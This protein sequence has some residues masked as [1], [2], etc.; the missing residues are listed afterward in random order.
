MTLPTPTST[1]IEVIPFRR[2][3][4]AEA[5]FY[6]RVQSSPLSAAPLVRRFVRACRHARV[7]NRLLKPD[8]GVS[9]R[10][11]VGRGALQIASLIEQ[12]GF[13]GTLMLLEARAGRRPA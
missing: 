4:R 6:L 5:G 8:E 10:C 1:A 12:V 9:I 3:G 7:H 13:T 11:F 2:I